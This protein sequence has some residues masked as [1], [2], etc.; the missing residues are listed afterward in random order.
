MIRITTVDELNI[1]ATVHAN[2]EAR[3]AEHLAETDALFRDLRIVLADAFGVTNRSFGQTLR[4][5]RTA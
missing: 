3:A 1:L 5:K 2:I 4:W